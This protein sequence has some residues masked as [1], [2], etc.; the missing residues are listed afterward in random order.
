MGARRLLSLAGLA[1]SAVAAVALAAP[2]AA[3]AEAPSSARYVALGDSYVAG[4]GIPQ[5]DGTAC[6][7]SDQN[8]PNQV[9]RRFFGTDFDDVSCS[10]AKTN[11]ITEAQTDKNGTVINAPQ[12]DSIG[13]RT[14]LVTLGIGGNDIGF[15]RIVGTCVQ[16]SGGDPTNPGSPCRNYY[17]GSGTDQL[18]AAIAATAPQVDAIIDEIKNRSPYTKVRV[19][20]YPTILPSGDGCGQLPFAQGDMD[21]LR[22][23]FDGLNDMLAQQASANGVGFV[24]T[25]T[26]SVGH[27]ACQPV[28]TKWVEGLVPES[29]AT[30]VHPNQLGMTNTASR[31]GCSLLS[32]PT[33]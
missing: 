15:T 20:G 6:L 22:G 14:R 8:Y 27:D 18:A 32:W 17:T 1:I 5:Q 3:V 4:P 9:G 23:V 30:A 2:T 16:L 10:G 24:D 11:H 12:I 19:V 29:P 28:G 25:A 31:V 13:P 33:T 26:S 7:R 21:Y